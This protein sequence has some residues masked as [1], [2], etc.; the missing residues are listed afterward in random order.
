MPLTMRTDLF[1]AMQIGTR[2]GIVILRPDLT[3]AQVS[4]AERVIY[5]EFPPE[6]YGTAMRERYGQR[7]IEW[8]GCE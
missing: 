1:A 3:P 2:G 6:G 8:G 4:E 5:R 7:V